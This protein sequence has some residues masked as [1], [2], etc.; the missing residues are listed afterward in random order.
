MKRTSLRSVLVMLGL[1]A[2]LCTG[3]ISLVA[4]G[5]GEDLVCCH[6]GGPCAQGEA[7]CRK[8]KPAAA[9]ST[10]QPMQCVADASECSDGEENLN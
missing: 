5:G 1:S 6:D 7:C 8:K 2:M 3:A 4:E 10:T 9:C